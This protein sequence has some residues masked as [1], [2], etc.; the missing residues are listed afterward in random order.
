MTRAKV[1]SPHDEY[2][3]RQ[4]TD[5]CA[6]AR[7]QTTVR[8]YTA[9]EGTGMGGQGTPT[10]TRDRAVCAHTETAEPAPSG[11]WPCYCTLPES[12]RARGGSHFPC[13]SLS[14][15]SWMRKPSN[16]LGI[17]KSPACSWLQLPPWLLRCPRS[18]W[19]HKQPSAQRHGTRHQWHCE[20][21]KGNAC[22]RQHV[23]RAVACTGGTTS[24][25][26]DHTHTR[27]VGTE[28]PFVYWSSQK[29]RTHRKS[30]SEG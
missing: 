19:H 20:H 2:C 6:H 10:H 28:D 26:A 12:S 25:G 21:R 14:G 9:A 16:P 7:L 30:K 13:P 24:P 15:S 11:N 1:S 23:V 22:L 3:T 8:V 5:S 27:T 17:C 4:T 18:P 29:W